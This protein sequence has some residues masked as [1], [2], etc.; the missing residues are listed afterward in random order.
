MERSFEGMGGMSLRARVLRMSN[1]KMDEKYVRN[2]GL[3]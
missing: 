3:C 2:G 1:E